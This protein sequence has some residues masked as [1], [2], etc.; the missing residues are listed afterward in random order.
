[1][2]EVR[3]NHISQVYTTAKLLATEMISPKVTSIRY[4]SLLVTVND[5]LASKKQIKLCHILSNAACLGSFI[6]RSPYVATGRLNL[7]PIDVN[8]YP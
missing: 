1:M 5:I 7:I 2:E 8:A 6:V 4:I 3:M